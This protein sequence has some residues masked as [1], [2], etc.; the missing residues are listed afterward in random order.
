MQKILCKPVNAKISLIITG[1][2]FDKGSQTHHAKLINMFLVYVFPVYVLVPSCSNIF[3]VYCL[4]LKKTLGSKGG[5][6]YM[7]A[8]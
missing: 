6:Q 4:Q 1:Q 7:N 8:N 2:I 5:Q 3:R